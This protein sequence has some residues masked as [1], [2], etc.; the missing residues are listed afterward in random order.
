MEPDHV[1]RRVQTVCLL[2]I[3]A[4]AAAFALFFLQS[5]LIPVVLAFMLT[6]VLTP[7]VSFQVERLRFPHALAVTATMLLGFAAIFGLY[8]VVYIS[9]SQLAGNGNISEYQAHLETLSQRVMRSL[10]LES[11]GIDPEVQ[12]NPLSIWPTQSV[13]DLLKSLLQSVFNIVSQGVLMLIF[14]FF[15]L[16][17]HTGRPAKANKTWAEIDF[18]VK[19]YLVA[20]TFLSVVAGILVWA[21]LR[22]LGL[23]LAIVFGLMAFLL[24]FIP[25][26]GS[27]IATLL[28]LPLVLLN[29]DIST[30]TAVLAIAL[31]GALQIVLGSFVEPRVLGDSLDLHPVTVLLAL[32]FWGTMWGLV[33]MLL[34]APMTAILRILMEKLEITAPIGRLL[35]GRLGET[36][37]AKPSSPP[38]EQP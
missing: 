9:L 14:L 36:M 6:M 34:A 2:I 27:I 26:I 37:A 11:W 35:A 16:M 10:P 28:P 21:I 3:S 22:I 31:P 4:V 15:L 32:I 19:K 38:G 18:H 5:V 30:T 8:L 7:V 24:N 33:G 25:S 12:N 20:K 13:G 29:P 17:G 23:E 1:E